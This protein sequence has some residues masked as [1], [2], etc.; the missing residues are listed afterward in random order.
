MC[1]IFVFLV[2]KLAR[3]RLSLLR[4]LSLYAQLLI[5]EAIDVAAYPSLSSFYRSHANRLGVDL[6]NGQG[7][8]NRTRGH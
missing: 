2:A 6:W 1:G 5:V 3:G 7:Y 4:S 8:A